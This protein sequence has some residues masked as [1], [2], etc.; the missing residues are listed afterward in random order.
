MPICGVIFD[1]GHTL[2]HLDGTWPE[3]F[4]GGGAD[5]AAF[6][7]AER[8]GV[9]G[10]AFAQAFL[11]R[12][13]EGHVQA[14]E[15]NREV[16]AKSSMRWTFTQFGLPNPEPS[17]VKGAIQ[18]F[19][20]YED[21]H[22]HVDP[23]AHAVLHALAD[24]GLFL[25]MF[26]NATDDAFIQ[27]LVDRLGLRPWLKP[28]LSSAG[29]GIR[30]PDP[31]ALAPFAQAWGLPP[32]CLVMVGDTLDADVMGAQRAGMCSVWIRSREDARQEGTGGSAGALNQAIVP[33]LAI[34]RLDD[35]PEKLGDLERELA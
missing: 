1:L 28:A 13:I 15:T 11:A 34:D 31:A 18:A 21:A 19:L 23:A 7:D 22:W 2:M 17:L 8:L 5:L 26:S 16:T 4:E 20:A 6:I 24:R 32:D 9:D 30:K 33:D 10:R 25:G 35:L 29:V 3:M 27:H 14:R 12:Q